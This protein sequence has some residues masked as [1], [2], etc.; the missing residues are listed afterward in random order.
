M[1]AFDCSL[2]CLLT[3]F[4]WGVNDIAS[5]ILLHLIEMTSVA[6]D[7]IQAKEGQQV[8]IQC[9]PSETGTMIIWFR[10]LDKF[11]MEFIASFSNSGMKKKTENRPSSDF[12]YDQIRQHTLILKSFNTASDSGIYSCAS[13]FKGNELKFGKVTRLVGG[14]FGSLNLV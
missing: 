4:F 5:P 6:G 14:E 8:E 2:V 1:A 3:F 10:M 7:E 11:Q 9:S 12:N 13:L